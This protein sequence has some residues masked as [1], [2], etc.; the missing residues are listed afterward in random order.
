MTVNCQPLTHRECSFLPVIRLYIYLPIPALQIESEKSIGSS[1]CVQRV[2]NPGQWIAV[3]LCDLIPFS[4]V[5]AEAG[6][7]ILS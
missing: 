1:Q 5:Y 7:P 3:F 4:V 2:V 6:F